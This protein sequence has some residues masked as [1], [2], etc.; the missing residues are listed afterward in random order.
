M[1]GIDKILIDGLILGAAVFVF[2]KGTNMLEK[3][4]VEF[5]KKRAEEAGETYDPN[6]PPFYVKYHLATLAVLLVIL[7]GALIKNVPAIIKQAGVVMLAVYF[8]NLIDAH[9][10]WGD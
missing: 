5:A 2:M 10:E 1:A 3:K 9:T 7:S 4:V 8:A 6:N